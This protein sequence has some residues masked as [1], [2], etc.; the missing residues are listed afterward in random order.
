MF[1]PSYGKL[2]RMALPLMFGTF[3]QSIVVVTDAAFLS[4]LGNVEFDAS[5][6]AGL[7]YLTFFML[8]VGIAD[9]SQIIIARRV[10]NGKFKEVGIILRHTLFISFL[11]AAL[12][13]AIHLLGSSIYIPSITKHQGIA[14]NMITFLQYRSWGIFFAFFLLSFQGFYM[15]IAQTKVIIYTTLILASVNVFFDYVLIFGAYGFPKL[16]LRGAALASSF[17][18]TGAFIFILVFTTLRKYNVKYQL[19]QHFRLNIKLVWRI[20]KISS[21]LMIQGVLAMGAW[22]V[23]FILIEQ[24]GEIELAA[25][26]VIRSLYFFAFVPIFG[27]GATTRTFVSNLLGARR[28]DLIKPT[29][30]RIIVLNISILALLFHGAFIY[31]EYFVKWINEDP[32]VVQLAT[33]ILP[34]VA[35][36][37][38]L[39]GIFSMFHQMVSGSGN[40]TVSFIIELIS[41]V[42]YLTLA[43]FVVIEWQSSLQDVW[44]VEYFYFS[45]IGGCSIFYL[46]FFDWKSKE[47]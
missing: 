10:G 33:R 2:M 26:Q 9:G 20:L 29:V 30:L 17:A 43:Y 24:I 15:G 7:L 27:F 13:F 32:E 23:F 45:M 14:G 34:V 38:F 8:G 46:L 12:I 31:P 3:V 47:V 42:L 1:V 18:E 36:A 25:S 35:G 22:T 21:P 37:M 28:H 11:V 39:Y 16:G 41:I 6:N 44:L 40:T 5:G 4:R 19:L